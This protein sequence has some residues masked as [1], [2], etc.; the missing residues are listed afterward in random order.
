ML[1]FLVSPADMFVRGS[2]PGGREQ[3]KVMFFATDFLQDFLLGGATLVL[4]GQ[5]K[6]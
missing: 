2:N 6:N 3:M 1:V 4:V 5:K